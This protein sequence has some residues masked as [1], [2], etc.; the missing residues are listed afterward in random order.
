MNISVTRF[1]D[2]ARACQGMYGQLNSQLDRLNELLAILR[3]STLRDRTGGTSGLGPFEWAPLARRTMSQALRTKRAALR[4]L[5]RIDDPRV[6]RVVRIW[7][8]V[9]DANVDLRTHV[10]DAID[11]VDGRR[12]LAEVNRDKQRAETLVLGAELL[13]AVDQQAANEA[14]G[15]SPV[16]ELTQ[17]FANMRTTL[18]A[19]LANPDDSSF[20][21]DSAA[22]F[23]EEERA[24]MGA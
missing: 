2:A 20:A 9:L 5:A 10:A 1:V 13:H 18:S 21:E 8:G 22:F 14:M 11:I 6:K 3:N 4:D 15:M 17:A 7:L 19:R 12:T 16:E 24:R 23:S